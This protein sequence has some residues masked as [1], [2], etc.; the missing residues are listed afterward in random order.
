MHPGSLLRS[1]RL[2]RRLS[3]LQLAGAAG[4]SARHLSFVETGRSRPGRAVLAALARALEL[5]HRESN[6][7]LRAAGE[8]PLYPEHG[9]DA[10]EA[11][12][13]RAALERMLEVHMPLPAMVTDHGWNLV[14]GNAAFLA[15]SERLAAR[16]ARPPAGRSLLEWLFARDGLRPLL[17]N[18]GVV[19]P[20]LLERARREAV[21]YPDLDPLVARLAAQLDGEPAAAWADADGVVVPL[22]LVLDGQ[23]LRLFSVL[24]S[25]GSALDAHLE[26]L[27]IEY[28]FAEDAATLAWL[29]ALAATAR[30]A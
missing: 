6:R 23:D 26:A 7:L 19:A 5:P 8:R 3:Q 22:H 12:P 13:L 9:L 10:A 29:E 18:F 4:I 15:L 1:H 20:L 25:F 17:A 16:S 24:A 14:R 21:R 11:A 27:R 30:A 2:R 28:F